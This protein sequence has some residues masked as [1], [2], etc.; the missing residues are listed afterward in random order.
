MAIIIRN[1]LLFAACS[2][3]VESFDKQINIIEMIMAFFILFCVAI[4][5]TYFKR[6][7]YINAWKNLFF[8]TTS[9]LIFNV[10]LLISAKLV[11]YKIYINRFGG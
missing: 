1:L 10:V 7:R 11:A 3:I 2:G 4:I 5:I 9:L 8:T 6:N